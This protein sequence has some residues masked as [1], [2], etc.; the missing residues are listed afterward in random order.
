[1]DKAFLDI[2]P[3]IFLAPLFA[4]VINGLVLGKRNWRLAAL[5]SLGMALLSFVL[6]AKLGYD[7]Y[8]HVFLNPSEYPDAS[9][10][11]WKWTWL[12]FLSGQFHHSALSAELAIYLDPISVLMLIVITSIACLV[13]FYSIGYMKEDPSAGRFFALLSLFC[14]SMLG[15]VVSKNILQMYVFWE[16]VGVS[17]YSLIGFWYHKPSAVAA[18]KKAFI[19]TRFADAFFLL[20]LICLAYFT[21]SL[22]FADLN[23]TKAINDL[24]GTFH[25]FGFELP[26]LSTACLLVFMGAWGKSAM[27]PLHVW[28]PDAMEGP[29][30]VSSI[31]HSATMVVAGVFL[32]ARLFPLFSQA[33]G[34]LE[35]IE[36]IGIF[37]A[38]FAAIVACTQK[39]IKRILAFSTLSQIGY[40]MLSLGVAKTEQGA[41]NLLAYNASMYHIFTH[42][43]FKCLLFLSAGLIIHAVHSN[44][45][46]Q[47]GGL[48]SKLKGTYFATL[49][50]CLAISGVPP[51]S[52]FFSKDEILLVAWQGGHQVT[53]YAALLASALTA[54]YMFR[55]FFLIFHGEKRGHVEE[56][57]HEDKVMLTPILILTIPSA[58]IGYFAFDFFQMDWLRGLGP[59]VELAHFTELPYLA[60]GASVIGILMAL[61]LYGKGNLSRATQVKKALAPLSTVIENKFYID[62][63]YLL[64]THK[65]IFAGIAAPVKW[66]DRTIVDGAM[67]FIGAL[68]RMGGI[69]VRLLQNG[70]M[71]FYL[72]IALF[73]LCAFIYLLKF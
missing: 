53:F 47:M 1:M 52:G 30:P 48:R 68:N 32:S 71:Q 36:L 70:Q 27:F 66:F 40:M 20:G 18:S 2:V 4:F 34:V 21:Q 23:Q 19:V 33:P 58:V 12:E 45:I 9:L 54:F 5:F 37:T 14:F 17:S 7:Y 49:I 28:L 11:A 62:E 6:S 13:N 16:L 67:N 55:F 39:D 51:F 25:V 65:I 46:L 73:G 64:I 26:L 50:A 22:D 69:T 72:G 35:T 59:S 8:F 60:S 44:D 56:H 10:I 15:L 24:S 29:T 63:V 31:I 57:I 38:V 3:L 61:I 43:F 41:L 42:A